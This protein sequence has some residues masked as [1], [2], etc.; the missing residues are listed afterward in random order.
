MVF[1]TILRV[2]GCCIC[3][4][5]EFLMGVYGTFRLKLDHCRQMHAW[6]LRKYVGGLYHCFSKETALLTSG[7]Y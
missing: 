2:L 5:R 1:L 4:E 3:V 7:S 6:V